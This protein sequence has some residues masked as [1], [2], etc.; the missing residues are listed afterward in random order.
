MPPRLLV[1]LDYESLVK[2]G[3][4]WR[5]LYLV[6][7]QRGCAETD[8][9]WS[10]YRV[11]GYAAEQRDRCMRPFLFLAERNQT[12]DRLRQLVEFRD[13]YRIFQPRL[14]AHGSS[15]GLRFIC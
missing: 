14:A 7:I 4:V 8:F 15:P 13:S 5:F 11:F 6:R 12:E 1:F 3:S 9:M 10:L 2:L